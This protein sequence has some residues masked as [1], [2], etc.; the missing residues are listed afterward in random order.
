MVRKDCLQICDYLRRAFAA[1]ATSKHRIN[2]LRVVAFF[3]R[4]SADICPF[5]GEGGSDLAAVQLH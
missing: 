2:G 5:E 4:P 3:G 1:A